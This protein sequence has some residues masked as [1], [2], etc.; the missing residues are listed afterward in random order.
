MLNRHRLQPLVSM[1]TSGFFPARAGGHS[2]RHKCQLAAL[3]TASYGFAI[4][5]MLIHALSVS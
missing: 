3:E 1:I 2:W 4:A 5:G